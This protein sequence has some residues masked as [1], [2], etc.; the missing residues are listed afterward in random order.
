MIEWRLGTMGFGYADWNGPFYLAGTKPS[1]YLAHYARYFNSVELD[2]TFYATP[3]EA[4]VRHWAASVPDDFRFAAKTPRTVTHE[5]TL[6]RNAP[7]MLE[8]VDT[9]RALEHKL[10]II[11]IQFPPS[12]AA[13][14]APKLRTLLSALP[15]DVRFAVEFRHSSWFNRNTEQ[16]LEDHRVAL[17]A[18]EYAAPA[19]EVSL[20]TD[21]LYIRW[22]GEHH[23]FSKLNY[24]QVDLTDRLLW[25]Q[26]EL[27]A[28]SKRV[29][30]IWGYFNNDYSG[31]AI[32][33]CQRF[34]QMNGLAGAPIE[35]PRQP[36]LFD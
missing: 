20:T 29:K 14:N 28:K 23:R 9:M 6:E 12:F 1:E 25:W 3:D 24:E 21:M 11:L 15:G 18:G 22:V 13:A 33:T 16:L 26:T 7:L 8:F 27:H 2:T 19:R 30:Q 5:G 34:K 10:G 35:A 31:Y 36:T 32:A 4:R 17:V